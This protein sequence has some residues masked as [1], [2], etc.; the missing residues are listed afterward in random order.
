M[1]GGLG[2]AVD[3]YI[4]TGCHTNNVSPIA[5]RSN[6]KDTTER[7]TLNGLKV[8]RVRVHTGAAPIQASLK[9]WNLRCFPAPTTGTYDRSTKISAFE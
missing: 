9:R 5:T 3:D 2:T 7:R 6:L 8:V 4:T 1:N